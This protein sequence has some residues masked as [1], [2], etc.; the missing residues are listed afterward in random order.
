VER[1]DIMKPGMS[2]SESSRVRLALGFL[3]FGI[4]LLLWAW[5]SWMYRTSASATAEIVVERGARD[6]SSVGSATSSHPLLTVGVA[7][8]VVF[9]VGAGAYY[10]LIGRSREPVPEGD[11]RES[12]NRMSSYPDSEYDDRA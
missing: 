4:M 3:V 9:V 7:V 10:W 2:D 1:A 12:D 6:S 5:G 11:I 8:V